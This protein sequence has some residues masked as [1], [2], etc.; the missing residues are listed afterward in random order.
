L[1]Y[2]NTYR[3]AREIFHSDADPA[4]L[5]Q[6]DPLKLGQYLTSRSAVSRELREV[7]IYRGCPAA[8]KDP[9]G[10]GA[11]QRQT[12][13]QE[14]RGQGKVKFIVRTLRYPSD[15]PSSPPQEKGI[16]VALAV[17]FVMMGVRREYDVGIVVSTDTD[18]V[19]A[20]EAVTALP[21]LRCE[22]AAFSRPK[23][24]CR[25]L[26]VKTTPVWCHWIGEPDYVSL[27]DHTD[28]NQATITI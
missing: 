14:G 10:Y 4:F 7:R 21:S 16:D 23:V 3:R 24:H 18:L 11:N 13:V 28:Y 5:G 9:R 20:L 19:P 27:S 22:V 6:V 15:W 1:T 12:V 17:D 25:R 8:L 26:S 2:Q